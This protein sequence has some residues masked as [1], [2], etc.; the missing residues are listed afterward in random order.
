MQSLNPLIEHYYTSWL[1][2]RVQRGNSEDMINPTIAIFKILL[3]YKFFYNRD[4]NYY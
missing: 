2:P 1:A 3:T 4:K